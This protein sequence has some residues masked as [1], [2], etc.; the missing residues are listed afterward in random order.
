MGCVIDEAP[1]VGLHALDGVE[2]PVGD[3]GEVLDRRPHHRI[4]VA[5]GH[6]E[7]VQRGTEIRGL[8]PSLALP[9]LKSVWGLGVVKRSHLTTA[10][11]VQG[12]LCHGKN[13]FRKARRPQT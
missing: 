9:T 5:A 8:P 7:I 1:N 13:L 2:R 3:V 11:N 6:V 10:T 12:V 4:Q